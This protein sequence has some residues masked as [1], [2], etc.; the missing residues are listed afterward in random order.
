MK[1][2]VFVAGVF[3]LLTV[4]AV[5][6]AQWTGMPVWNSPKGGTGL[7]ISGDWGRPNEV[8]GKGNAFGAR[9]SLGIGTIGFTAGV[10]SYKPDGRN[11]RTTSV[12]G[13]VDFRLIGGSLLPVAVN[14]QAGAGVS[15][16]ITGVPDYPKVVNVTA[17]VGFSLPLP[18]PGISIEPYFSPGL[19]YRRETD[20]VTDISASDTK[21]GFTLGANL[22]FGMMGI[23]AAYDYQDSD[24]GNA[25]VFGLG[26]HVALRLPVGM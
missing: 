20:A 2:A 19:R 17:A 26:A 25:N 14:L 16:K 5:A 7:T 23:H 15:G 10:A 22:G 21:F 1:H 3:A 4:P 11:D 6:G 24:A 18:T 13:Q 12:G 8:Y 9:A